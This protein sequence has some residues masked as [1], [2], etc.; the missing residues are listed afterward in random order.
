MTKTAE[1]KCN[2]C[3]HIWEP[4]DSVRSVIPHELVH[5]NRTM[6]G[7]TRFYSTDYCPLCETEKVAERLSDL[8]EKIEAGGCPGP[9]LWG[10]D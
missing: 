1:F 3:R 7:D 9:L 8:R 2:Q 6:N 4:T 10:N 5:E